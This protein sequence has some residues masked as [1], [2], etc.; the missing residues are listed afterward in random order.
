MPSCSTAESPR[1]YTITFEEESHKY[2]SNI[3]GKTIDYVSGT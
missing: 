3:N 2:F 1:G